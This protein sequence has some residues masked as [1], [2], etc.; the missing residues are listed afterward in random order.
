MLTD[1]SNFF[2]I[3][4]DKRHSSL[5]PDKQIHKGLGVKE[6]NVLPDSLVQKARK[7]DVRTSTQFEDVQTYY[8]IIEKHIIKKVLFKEP[9]YT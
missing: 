3:S 7:V 2:Y 4:R 8:K 5:N 6:S 9:W 1:Q